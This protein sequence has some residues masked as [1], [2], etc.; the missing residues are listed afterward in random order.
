MAGITPRS[1]SLGVT[2]ALVDF[3]AEESFGQAS[4]RFRE[5]Y[6]FSVEVPNS[7]EA[8]SERPSHE[9]WGFTLS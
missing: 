9:E 2:R 6:G 4:K 3:G 8:G 5:H 7:H 1:F